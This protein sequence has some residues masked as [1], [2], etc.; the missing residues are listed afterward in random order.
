MDRVEG[1]IMSKDDFLNNVPY[2]KEPY[3]GILVS[4]D[5]GHNQYKIA[6]QL[7]ENQV[8]LVDQVND[9]EVLEKLREW[10]P[11][12]NEIQMQYGVNNDPGNYS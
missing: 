2:T 9:K 7:S 3:E 10:V 12:V 11:R 1:I 4:A 8:L 5:T 6:V